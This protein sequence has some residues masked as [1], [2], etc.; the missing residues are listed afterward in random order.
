LDGGILA[1]Y[2]GAQGGSA[3]R[4]R[5]ARRSLSGIG[6]LRRRAPRR[7]RRTIDRMGGRQGSH[8]G[9]HLRGIR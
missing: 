6:S 9:M 3:E 2:P 5:S 4:Y 8:P 1:A 7:V